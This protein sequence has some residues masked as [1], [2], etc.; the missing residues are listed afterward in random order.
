MTTNQK[1]IM[2]LFS[3]L[4]FS[5][6]LLAQEIHNPVKKNDGM[7]VKWGFVRAR[8]DFQLEFRET[9]SDKQEVGWAS[10]TKS[11]FNL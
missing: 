5:R 10:S 2:V 8:D 4:M 1:T 7:T 6:P 9:F 11:A 3:L